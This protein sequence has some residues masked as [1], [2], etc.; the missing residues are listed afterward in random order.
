MITR[1][2]PSTIRALRDCGLLKYFILSRMRQHMEL[3]EFVVLAW[4]LVIEAF[5]I[6][7][8]VA[9]ILVD[10]FYLLTG[11]SRRGLPISLSR[12]PLGGEM[13]RDYI[14]QYCNPGE[15]PRKD[16]KINIHD[17]CDFPLRTILFVITKLAGTATVHVANK[18]Y[19]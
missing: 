18:S 10:D 2:D 19:M 13:V 16:G 8:K 3:L 15:E 7:D 17:V 6:G 4:D 12:F 9:P 5:H 1:N 11:L 14:L